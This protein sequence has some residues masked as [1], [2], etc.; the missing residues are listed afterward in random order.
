[1]VSISADVAPAIVAR[2]GASAGIAPATLTRLAH[3]SGSRYDGVRKLYADAC[4]RAGKLPR[5]AKSC[6]C[7]ATA[8]R[9]ALVQDIFASL[10][11]SAN[12][13]SLT[14]QAIYGCGR[15]D[16]IADRFSVLGLPIELRRA[17]ISI[18]W[19]AVRFELGAGRR[20]GGSGVDVLRTIGKADVLLAIS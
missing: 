3:G 18:M 20:I 12:L 11:R 7:G 5:P 8:R 4:A 15:H 14:Y 10:T 9:S 1:V 17:Y 6:W 19:F 16:R 13:S 2:T